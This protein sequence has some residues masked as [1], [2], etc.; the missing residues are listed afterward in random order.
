MHEDFLA[1][2]TRIE[3]AELPV[4]ECR[5]PLLL[6]SGDDD[7]MWPSSTFS[8]LVVARLAR[9]GAN[10]ECTH[11]RYPDAGH[12]FVMPP[13]MPVPL[14]VPAHPLTGVAYAFGGTEAGNTAAQADAWPRVV[15]F[16]ADA[17][18]GV[19][20]AVSGSRRP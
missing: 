18:A 15:E 4:E 16:L 20:S 5:G 3:H 9:T 17:A 6:V 10:V 7:Q 11:L 13:G 2:P 14:E 1:D 12:A 8:E 19:P